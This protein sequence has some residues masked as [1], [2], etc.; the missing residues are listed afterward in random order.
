MLLL[1]LPPLFRSSQSLSVSNNSHLTD[2]VVSYLATAALHSLTHLEIQNCQEIGANASFF[3]A[4]GSLSI[5]N[6]LTLN[7]LTSLTDSAFMGV[8]GEPKKKL[9]HLSFIDCPHISDASFFQLAVSCKNLRSLEV[10]PTGGDLDKA[11]SDL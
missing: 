3:G 8:F 5:L 7:G 6:T 2:S 4:I 1:T 10:R 9:H 11:V